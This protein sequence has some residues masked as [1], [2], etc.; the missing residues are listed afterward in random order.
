MG[1]IGLLHSHLA[2]LVWGN[3]CS[4]LNKWRWDGLGAH[5]G[6]AWSLQLN[7]FYLCCEDEAAVWMGSTKSVRW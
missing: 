2:M 5:E 7:R 3:I 1:G 4:A 6:T